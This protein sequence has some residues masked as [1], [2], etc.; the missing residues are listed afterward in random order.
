MAYREFIPEPIKDKINSWDLNPSLLRAL[1][2]TLR[3]ELRTRPENDLRR[4]VAPVR[5]YV[6]RISVSDPATGERR[7]FAFYLD[8]WVRSGERTVIEAIDLSAPFSQ[9][10]NPTK[11]A[12]HPTRPEFT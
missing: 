6:L 4:I 9:I 3:I 5:C 11:A 12:K 10:E 7:D 2:E 1:W 8:T